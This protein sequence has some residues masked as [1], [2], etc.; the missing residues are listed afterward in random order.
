MSDVEH[1]EKEPEKKVV[2]VEEEKTDSKKEKESKPKENGKSETNEKSEPETNGNSDST[3]VTAAAK[4]KSGAGDATDSAPSEG[5]TPEKKAKISTEEKEST[6]G[7]SE[8]ASEGAGE[9]KNM[10]Y[11]KHF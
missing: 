9:A 2:D 4:R 10:S 1:V 7:E 5:V 6:N 8:V 11:Q 3:E